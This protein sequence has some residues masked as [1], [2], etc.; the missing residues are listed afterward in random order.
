MDLPQCMMCMCA[1]QPLT[2]RQ[3]QLAPFVLDKPNEF[4]VLVSFL[5]DP[6][7]L[8]AYV[9]DAC[10]TSAIP[11]AAFPLYARFLLDISRPQPGTDVVVC[12]DNFLAMEQ[13]VRCVLQARHSICG[14]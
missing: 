14:L 10:T 2:Q 5:R 7:R 9:R 12:R 8:A 6:A 1:G 3:I 11:N 4:A 13:H